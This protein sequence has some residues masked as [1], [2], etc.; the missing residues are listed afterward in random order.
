MSQDSP[1]PRLGRRRLLASAAAAALVGAAG[2]GDDAE[3]SDQEDSVNYVPASASVL[4]DVDMAVTENDATRR[5][6]EAYG[7]DDEENYFEEFESRTGLDPEE[8]EEVLAF[9]DESNADDEEGSLVVVGPWDEDEAVDALQD[10]TGDE[11]EGTDHE[12]G[13]IYEPQ[14]EAEVYLGVAA[15]GQY[16]YGNESDVQACLDVYEGSGDGLEG[17]LRD[18]FEDAR[19]SEPASE[20]G[21]SQ[22][23]DRGDESEDEDQD[24]EADDETEEE[25]G[26][27]DDVDYTQYVAAATD[28][29]RAYLP[30]EDSEEVPP[31][32]SLSIYNSLETAT[33]TYFAA[34]E[35]VAV[36]VVM[37]AGD[38]EVAK[39]VEDFTATALTFLVS[40]VDDEDVKDELAQ[41]GVKRDG[42][43]V[44]VVYRTDAEGA[45]T[46]VGWI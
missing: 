30:D 3:R 44:T 21:A 1:L 26:D 41:V 9:S 20:E 23:M 31:G 45:A 40:D 28:D 34:E 24:G 7:Q 36:D 15:E 29:P 19:H 33:A 43:E 16:V 10:A 14:G 4:V 22:D 17:P 5:I 2:C 25:S 38:E 8:T 11:Y 12:A 39:E 13:T 18:A 35:E 6:V 27:E 46:L 42:T 37:R 32:V